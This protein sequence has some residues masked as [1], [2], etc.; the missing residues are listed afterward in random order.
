MLISAL[1]AS[2]TAAHGGSKVNTAHREVSKASTVKLQ[3]NFFLQS[4][5]VRLTFDDAYVDPF[6]FRIQFSIEWTSR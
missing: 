2:H 5:A 6:G 3:S 1:L 4:F